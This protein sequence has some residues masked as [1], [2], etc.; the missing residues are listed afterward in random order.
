MESPTYEDRL[1]N[2]DERLK[3]MVNTQENENVE[4]TN[5]EKNNLEIAIEIRELLKIKSKEAAVLKVEAEK[6][7]ATIL[8]E[9]ADGIVTDMKTILT[10][11]QMSA[12]EDLADK[13]DEMEEKLKEAIRGPGEGDEE[14]EDPEK[15]N[16]EKVE[17]EIARRKEL[18]H[19]EEKKEE[20]KHKEEMGKLT[21]KARTNL[22]GMSDQELENYCEMTKRR[23]R[24]KNGETNAPGRGRAGCQRSDDEE[25]TVNEQMHRRNRFDYEGPDRSRSLRGRGEFRNENRSRSAGRMRNEASPPR[26]LGGRRGGSNNRDKGED[27]RRRE[28]WGGENGGRDGRRGANGSG[29]G[30]E[31]GQGYNDRRFGES[32]GRGGKR[33]NYF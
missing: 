29:K 32:R 19:Q 12:K 5:E 27:G 24:N 2:V 22:E 16:M 25:E 3:E 28:N 30:T 6:S 1:D 26:N 10:E 31:N 14:P 18:K 4:L 11:V 8:K 33:G 9:I 7:G 17:N 21:E 23:E 15:A 20:E 13:M